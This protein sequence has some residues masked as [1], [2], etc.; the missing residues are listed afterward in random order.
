LPRNFGCE[1]ATDR[2]ILTLDRNADAP[3]I[4]SWLEMFPADRFVLS[5]AHSSETRG[6][7]ELAETKFRNFF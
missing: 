2:H 4:I 3:I 7:A 5:Q 6:N 1:K